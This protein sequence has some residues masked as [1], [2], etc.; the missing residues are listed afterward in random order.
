MEQAEVTSPVGAH[1]VG[2]GDDPHVGAGERAFDFRDERLV[3]DRAPSVVGVGSA[4]ERELR[5]L[6]LGGAAVQD[7]VGLV[8]VWKRRF[9]SGTLGLL[10]SF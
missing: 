6:H 7:E 4:D 10:L 9:T 3:R 2:L 1:A 8:H 5:A